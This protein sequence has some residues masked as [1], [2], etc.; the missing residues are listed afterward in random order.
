MQGQPSCTTLEE[1]IARSDIYYLENAVEQG[2]DVNI[3]DGEGRVPL[4]FASSQG[5]LEV[6]AIVLQRIFV[7]KGLFSFKNYGR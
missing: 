7:N 5:Q 1:A 3:P 6:S 2:L 4:V